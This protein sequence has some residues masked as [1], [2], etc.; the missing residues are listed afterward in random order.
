M[1]RFSHAIVRE[2]GDNCGQ[3]LTGAA[4]GTADSDRLLEQHRQ[5]VQTL[6][7]L[8]LEVIQLPPLSQFPDG[9]F[10]EDTAVIF[11]EGGIITNPGA[12]QR[13]GEA[14]AM[15]AALTQYLPIFRI[16]DP[17]RIDGGDVLQAG[18]HFFIGL[19]QRTNKEGARQ[20]GK[21]LESSG[22]TW[23]TVKVGDGLH[24]KSSVNYLG[25]GTMV[26][27]PDFASADLFRNYD[28]IVLDP[29]DAYAANSLRVNDHILMPAGFPR[30]KEQLTALGL[31]IL[32]LAVDEIRKM[33]G[34]LTCMSLRFNSTGLPGR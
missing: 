20:L 6:G 31:I 24:L 27:A 26:M 19:S 21:I 7:S 8:G 11:K 13:K 5:Y 17:G 12:D 3:G 28:R 2:P 22:H 33:D 16:M 32:E 15:A 18:N 4:L 14:R 10:V 29:D 9:Y 1:Y 34:G 23:R 30:A 25:R